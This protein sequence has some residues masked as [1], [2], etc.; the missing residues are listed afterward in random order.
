[1]NKR[2]HASGPLQGIR[3]IELAGIGPGPF[4]AMML[5]D[6]GADVVRVER[7]GQPADARAPLL[8]TR[9]RRSLGLNLK[10]PGATEVVLRLVDHSDVLIEGFRPGVAERL[11]VGPDVCLAR[12]PALVYGRMTG[13]GQDGPLAA[14]MGHDINFIAAAGVLAHIGRRDAPPTPPLN[15]VGDYAG[16]AMFLVAGLLAALVERTRS[17]HGQIVDAAML[18]GAAL[19]MIALWGAR[20][21]DQW[22]ED[23]RGVNLLDSGAPFYD[24]Y[25]TADHRWIAVGAI[26]KAPFQA[27]LETLDITADAY[28]N[29]HDTSTWPALRKELETTFA[30]RTLAQWQEQFAGVDA[31]VTPVLTMGEM[32]SHWQVQAR[33]T[34]VEHD[35]RLQPAP[36]P[37]FS[38]TPTHAQSCPSNP[39]VHS[40]EVLSD[41]GFDPTEISRLIDDG[42]VG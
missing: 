33:S 23:Q 6:M 2:L 7:P 10:R 31:C 12:N 3:V 38:R 32:T 37:R 19:L 14:T 11:G 25:Q 8:T 42:V 30:A 17:G 24:V 16:G 9:G 13:W 18:D 35:G 1:M 5:A 21:T 40:T 29:H 39:G 36:A 41:L 27:L 15:L 20:G 22:D 26:E 4:A 34:I 28:G